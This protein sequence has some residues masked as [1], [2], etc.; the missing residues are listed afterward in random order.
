[1]SGLFVA[2][3]AYTC[4]SDNLKSETWLMTMIIILYIPIH[5]KAKRVASDIPII[6]ASWHSS[7]K[8][9]KLTVCVPRTEWMRMAKVD[10]RHRLRKG[11]GRLGVWVLSCLGVWVV[12]DFVVWRSLYIQRPMK[13]QY[14]ALRLIF[15]FNMCLWCLTY[16]IICIIL[17]R[18]KVIHEHLFRWSV[19]NRLILWMFTIME[20]FMNLDVHPLNPWGHSKFKT[21]FG[22]HWWMW[23]RILNGSSPWNFKYQTTV[24]S[25]VG[26][27]CGEDKEHKGSKQLHCK[28]DHSRSWPYSNAT[29]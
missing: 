29:G 21:W 8:V 13:I 4:L 9:G 7:C 3:E 6:V 17:T 5:S 12:K 11:F 1:M 18:M 24:V 26:E 22:R 16:C 15:W 23:T 10:D 25:G 14:H 28:M 27:V 2:W 19:A 20:A